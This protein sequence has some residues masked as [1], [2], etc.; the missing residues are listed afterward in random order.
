MALKEFTQAADD[1]RKALHFEPRNQD[2]LDKLGRCL[3]YI[4]ED[5]LKRL[6]ANPNNEKIK[7]DLLAV[8]EDIRRIGNVLFFSFYRSQIPFK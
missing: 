7:K 6:Q 5:C 4:E 2:C 1:Y 8:R 3:L